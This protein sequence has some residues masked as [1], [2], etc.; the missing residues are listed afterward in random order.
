MQIVKQSSKNALPTLQK[1]D[2]K[3]LALLRMAIEIV[4]FGCL[5]LGI[6]IKPR[7][8]ESE[9]ILRRARKKKIIKKR[10]WSKNL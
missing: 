2:M 8:R 10:I 9:E 4:L 7:V 3:S 5:T 1:P 6:A